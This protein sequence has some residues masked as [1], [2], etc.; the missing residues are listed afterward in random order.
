MFSDLVLLKLVLLCFLVLVAIAATKAYINLKKGLS[1]S[2][3]KIS[4]DLLPRF[5]RYNQ[6]T[7]GQ[8]NSQTDSGVIVPCHSEASLQA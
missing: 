3:V 4:T 7:D 6:V 5:M 1:T 8:T 2:S